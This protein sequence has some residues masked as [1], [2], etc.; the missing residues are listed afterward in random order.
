MI[1]A[2]LIVDNAK[3]AGNGVIDHPYAGTDDDNR[4]QYDTGALNHH[5]TLR[6]NDL[7]DFAF[8]VFE[9]TNN[10]RPHAFEDMP[11]TRLLQIVRLLNGL[12]LRLFAGLLR[13]FLRLALT[14]GRLVYL[15]NG[16]LFAVIGVFDLVRHY[17]ASLFRL[18]M[19]RMLSAESAVFVHLQPVRI[20]FL[21]LHGIV[22]ALLALC[23]G[24][25]DLNSH[26]TAPPKFD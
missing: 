10:R 8:E 19:E 21:F 15:F 24:K 12:L 14:L 18:P 6:P 20:V 26:C 7:F 13:H 1:L 16:K 4:R 2:R 11:L 25:C 23:A 3:P 22:I 17:A 9:K 5:L